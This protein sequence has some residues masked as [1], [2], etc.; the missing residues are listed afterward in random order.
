MASIQ[1]LPNGKRRARYRDASGREHARHFDRKVDAQRWL[2][3]VTASI[4]TGQYVDPNAG[5]IT[6]RE[7]AEL[8]RAAQVHRPN[9]QA[10]VET[11]LRRHAFPTFGDRPLASI[12]PSD[13]QLWVRR[14]VVPPTT[15]QVMR[16]A[17]AAP[18]ELR[19][20]VL[21]VAG[22][23]VRQGEATGLT[24]DRVDTLRREVRIDRQLIRVVNG[25]PVFG[26]P[27]TDASYRTIPL[28]D[29]VVEALEGHVEELDVR[30]R[31]AAHP[32]R[33]ERQ[34]RAGTVGARVG[35]RDAGHVQPPVAGLGRPDPGG[36]RPGPRK[37]L[38]TVC[39]LL[40]VRT[41][42]SAGQRLGANGLACRPGSVRLTAG[43]PS[44]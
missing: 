19:G 1:K 24:L 32:A 4:V 27:K 6:F 13:V 9:S 34:D 25:Q 2:D 38:R 33:R 10:H 31:V 22:T 14:R 26:L 36:R 17:G 15:E 7:Y 20:L 8:W 3:E 28:P 40:R 44:I 29:V 42:V 21:F 35:G 5:R 11:M 37:F 41:T 12:V 43:R 18:P 23:G 30:I 39:G 16:L